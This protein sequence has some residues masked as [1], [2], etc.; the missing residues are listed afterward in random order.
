MGFTLIE[1]LVVIAIIAILA[2]MLLPALQEAKQRATRISCTNQ[3]KQFGTAY[4]MYADL[5]RQHLPPVRDLTNVGGRFANHAYWWNF[6]GPM[7]GYSHWQ[8]SRDPNIRAPTLFLCPDAK[9]TTAG[10]TTWYSRNV[11]GYG[12]NRYIPPAGTFGAWQ[13]HNRT[14][15]KYQAIESPVEKVFTADARWCALG[16]YGEFTQTGTPG[17]YYKV[18]RQRHGT[19][20]NV[21]YG[22]GHAEW[23][24]RTTIMHRVATQTLF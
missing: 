5:F 13:D 1:L 17:S 7:V 6:L 2:A 3:L 14:Y 23:V 18:D 16:G 22:D 19:G 11:M 24:S 4:H 21:L 12:Q 20:L 10:M 15:P 9:H 8:V